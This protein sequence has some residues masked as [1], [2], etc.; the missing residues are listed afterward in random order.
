MHARGTTGGVFRSD[1]AGATWRQVSPTNGTAWYYSF[2]KCDPT[3]P[4]H[5]VRLNA[6][7]QESWDGGKTWI[8]FAGG[9]V[10]SDHHILWIDPEAPALEILGTDGGL[11]TSW[12]RGRTWDHNESIV[13][14]QFYDVF[15]DDALPYYNVCGGLQDNGS[16]C[17]P[18]RTRNAFGPTNADWYRTHGGD[19]FYAVPDP[20]DNNLVYAEM[21]GGGVVRYDGR[22]G[23]SRNIKP[24]PKGGEKPYRFNWNAPILPSKFERNAVYMAANMLFRSADRGDSWVAISPDLTRALDRNK[25]PMRGSVPD[26]TALGRNEGTAEFSNISTIDESPLKAGVLAVGTDDGIIQV[27]K[28]GGKT[29]SKTDHFAGVPD[30]TFVSRVT[31]SRFAEGTIYATLDGHRSNDFKPYLMKTTDYGA[32]WTS[33]A[34]DLPDGGPVQVIREHFRQRNLLFVGTEFGVFASFDAGAHW[35]QLKGG[36]PGV[37][38][39]DIKIQERWND[40]VV[41]THGRGVYILDDLTPLEKL[42]EA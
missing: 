35:T 2:V 9:G 33:L 8:A 1:D 25:L 24:A 10:H 26:S 30:T 38:V 28:D 4:E 34:H 32:T 16:W 20:W 14:G 7:S 37:P 29:W 12:D 17:G 5:L 27:T 13:A 42:A 21:Q 39:H 36:I 19:G 23:Q 3:D 41:G 22:I 18:S 40:L 31:F 6:Q 11:Y 15:V